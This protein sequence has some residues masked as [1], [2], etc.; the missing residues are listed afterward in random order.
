MG[1]PS[2]ATARAVA[3]GCAEFLR[4]S[5][6]WVHAWPFPTERREPARHPLVPWRPVPGRQ[7]N[8]ALDR[9]SN[10]ALGRQANQEPDRQSSPALD[11]YPSPARGQQQNRARDAPSAAATAGLPRCAAH[12][13]PY[14][15]PLDA[16]A[17]RDWAQA[18]WDARALLP[19]RRV[20][21]QALLAL[22]EPSE[23]SE[24]SES[25]APDSP[26]WAQQVRRET[27]AP[28]PQRSSLRLPPEGAQA[29][30]RVDRRAPPYPVSLLVPTMRLAL[31]PTDAFRQMRATPRARGQRL[32]RGQQAHRSG[33][34]PDGTLSCLLLPRAACGWGAAVPVRPSFACG[35]S[36]GR[37]PWTLPEGPRELH[38]GQVAVATAALRAWPSSG[39]RGAEEERGLG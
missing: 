29:I 19:R 8:Q 36:P 3:E 30:P 4:A 9:Q 27:G 5:G 37:C 16:A 2:L 32:V 10:Q 35:N 39:Q 33:R 20:A 17:A 22:Q 31:G 12:L 13:D 11:R 24:V 21:R 1:A 34:R 26:P 6:P 18:R 28:L 25:L 38:A 23:V 7:A 14:A 15:A